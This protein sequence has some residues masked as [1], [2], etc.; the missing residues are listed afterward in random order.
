[1]E[2]DLVTHLTGD[3]RATR[4]TSMRMLWLVDTA[5][6]LPPSAWQC[7]QHRHLAGALFAE[8]L[9]LGSPASRSNG[10]NAESAAAPHPAVSRVIQAIESRFAEP[11]DLES[12][13]GIAGLTAQHLRKIF[14]SATGKTPIGYLWETRLEHA[15]RLITGT[16]LTLSEISAECGFSNPYHFSRKFRKAYGEPPR[17]YRKRVWEGG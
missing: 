10:R 12:L 16:G 11:L 17:D 8:F 14:K 15:H 1:L 2:P 9:R 13:A 4:R 3:A 6:G 7:L 5:L